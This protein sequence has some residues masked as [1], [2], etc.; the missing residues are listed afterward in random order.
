M[1]IKPLYTYVLVKPDVVEE[2]TKGGIIRPALAKEREQNRVAEGIVWDVGPN[3]WSDYGDGQPQ[4]KA[5]DRVY[6]KQYAGSKVGEFWLMFD[7]DILG[8]VT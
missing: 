1:K 2:V 6:F 7:I 5:G 8:V 3:A 4:A